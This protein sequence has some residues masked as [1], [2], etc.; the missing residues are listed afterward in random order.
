M[1][2]SKIRKLRKAHGMTQAALA[3]K[4][5]VC[6]QTV[7]KWEKGITDPDI[8][9][10]RHAAVLFHTSAAELLDPY[11]EDVGILEVVHSYRPYISDS[12]HRALSGYVIDSSTGGGVSHASVEAVAPDGRCIAR[13]TADENG[14]FIGSTGSEKQYAVRVTAPGMIYEIPR[15]KACPGETFMGGID[16]Q[17][18]TPEPALP[19]EGLWGDNILWKISVDGVLTLTGSGAMDDRYSAFSGRQERSP[20]RGLVKKV[21]I[22]PGIT[23]VGSHAFDGFICLE[24]VKL[25]KD[26]Q[27]IRGGAFMGCKKLKSVTFSSKLEEIGW[28]AFRGCVSL[29]RLTL[30]ASLKSIGSGAFAGCVSLSSLT[31]P[32]GTEILDEAFEFCGNLKRSAE[33]VI[34]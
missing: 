19:A 4:L 3:E 13:M 8:E 23:S 10:I 21:V 5:D 34:Q 25:G 24:E 17:C 12:C 28:N 31:I 9:V 16:I 22:R 33:A 27:K 11:T 7:M 2:G 26:V 30:P 15:V 14:F 20:Y 18:S 32:A 1:I 29:F 6:R